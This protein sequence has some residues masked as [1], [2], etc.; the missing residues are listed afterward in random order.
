MLVL[1]SQLVRSLGSEPLISPGVKVQI[2][3]TNHFIVTLLEFADKVPEVGVAPLVLSKVLL[4][5]IKGLI[6]RLQ[7][8]HESSVIYLQNVSKA[9]TSTPY[10]HK[11][12]N[13]SMAN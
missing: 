11:G 8:S 6:I 3:I 9:T 13:F 4:K 5:C 10:A 2:T 1:V 12:A 7:N